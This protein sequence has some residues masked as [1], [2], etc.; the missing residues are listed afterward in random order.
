MFCFQGEIERDRCSD[1]ES[2]QAIEEQLDGISGYPFS[3][4]ELTGGIVCGHG[5]DVQNEKPIG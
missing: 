3:F 1:P 5:W 4:D 2:R